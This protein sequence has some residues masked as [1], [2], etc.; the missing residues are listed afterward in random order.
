VCP[1]S[2]SQR[3]SLFAQLAFLH[4]AF[5]VFLRF[6]FLKADRV[7]RAGRQAVSETVA[8]IVAEELG[9]SV[10]HADCPF[11]AGFCAQTA[12]VTFLFI[13]SNNFSNHVPFTS[14]SECV[15]QVIIDFMP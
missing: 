13:N 10:Y 15:F 9:L 11:V 3:F 4:G 7:R 8:I 12:A 2:R 14:F 1:G 5:V 6:A